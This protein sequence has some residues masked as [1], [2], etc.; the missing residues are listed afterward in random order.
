MILPPRRSGEPP[1][2]LPPSARRIVIV[3]ANGSGKTR[4]TRQLLAGLSPEAARFEMSPLRA[5]FG[6]WQTNAPQGSIDRLYARALEASPLVTAEPQAVALPTEA[7]RL[8]AL[9]L[10]EEMH[11]LLRSKLAPNP[12]DT[13]AAPSTLDRVLTLW[14][15]FFP[16]NDVLRHDGGL[17]FASRTDV[18]D[19]RSAHSLSAGE[20]IVLYYFGAMLYAPEN[21]YVHVASPEL[22]LHP[23]TIRLLWDRIEQLRPDCTMIYT[24]HDLAFAASRTE[25]ATIWVRHCSGDA[26]TFDYDLLP[27]NSE[28]S[29][30]LYLAILGER[31][32]VLFIEGDNVHSIDAKLYPLIFQ[33]YTV[34]PL[35]SCDRV[36]EST[37]VFN[38]LAHFHHLDSRGIVDRDRR[39]EQEVAYLRKKKIMVPEVAE[40]ENLLMTEQ[41]VRLM[42]HINGGDSERVFQ[43]VKAAVMKLF[44][45]ELQNQ[46]MQHTRHRVKHIVEHRID[47]RFASIRQL[48][49]HMAELVIEI[50]PREL[51]KNFCRDFNSYLRHDDYAAVLRVFNHKSMLSQSNVGALCGCGDH[52]GYTAAVIRLL[53]QSSP[54]SEHARTILRS[55]LR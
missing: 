55:L 50:N 49:E 28:L 48:E 18:S 2:H 30:E 26:Q 43:K 45:T 23:S 52:K 41:L 53:R 32:P 11:R 38:S 36:I 16:G 37:R 54:Q 4:F 10:Q 39:S 42:A 9:M 44:R 22:F 17:L 15:E 5:L 46:A 21:A 13:F 7:E 51:Y 40:I 3:G 8:M 19:A 33:G 27:P 12:D 20:K 47:G 35:G 25:A 1:A 34:K 6:A 14:K 31:K 24:T 29:E